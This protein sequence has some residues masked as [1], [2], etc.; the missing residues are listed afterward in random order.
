MSEQKYRT[1]I[2]RIFSWLLILTVMSSCNKF[3]EI[4]PP[5]NSQVSEHVFANEQSVGSAISG[6][7]S[8][9]MS[10]P[11]NPRIFNA[12]TTISMGMYADEL[13]D[14]SPVH[15]Y[16]YAIMEMGLDDNSSQPI[17]YW[18]NAYDYI[19]MSNAIMDGVNASDGIRD[20][21]KKR[22]IGEMKLVRAFSHFYLVNV[23]GDVPYTNTSDYRL[24]MLQPRTPENE[25]Y[26]LI[27]ADLTSAIDAMDAAYPS[28]GRA[29]P[30]KYT[31]VALLS[32]VYLYLQ[33]WELAE[34]LASTVIDAGTYQLEPLLEDVFLKDSREPIWQLAVTSN[35][36][37]TSEGDQMV[38]A[39]NGVPTYYLRDELLNDFEAGDKRKQAWVRSVDHL[40]QT[41][42]YPYKY[43]GYTGST[44]Q[45]YCMMRLP[46]MYLIRAEART[47]Q[48][49]IGDAVKDVD[50]LRSRAG[51]PLIKDTD[52]A[53]DK[54]ALLDKIMHEKR[55]EFFAEW[56][57]RW[58]DLKRTGKAGQ[59]LGP[60]KPGWDQN[61]LVWPIP[62]KELL[63]NPNLTQNTGY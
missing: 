7:Y 47:Q 36:T 30:N 42:Y 26:E 17:S 57:H 23:F 55:I 40:S 9:M 22:I 48:N 51:L 12:S 2:N 25:V 16:E 60:I 46:E 62:A 58:F 61:D 38:P 28:A 1:Y 8:E 34:T 43:W 31:A 3:T 44:Q 14:F 11:P 4:D 32:R 18:S 45:Y 53:I 13:M 19:Y 20:A 56:G 52:P 21:V 27:I 39:S 50:I 33:Q 59:V 6:L 10:Y 35:N 29:R 63:A 37:N 49:K 5:R 41:W 54:T 24:N 15:D